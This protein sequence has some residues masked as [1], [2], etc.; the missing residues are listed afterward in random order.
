[1]TYGLTP[2]EILTLRE[3]AEAAG[4]TPSV[5]AGRALR[6]ALKRPKAAT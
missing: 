5:W 6:K 2:A 1:M 3:R 4:Q